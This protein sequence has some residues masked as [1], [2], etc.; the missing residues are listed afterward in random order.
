MNTLLYYKVGRKWVRKV[1]EETGDI[2]KGQIRRGTI[3]SLRR[4]TL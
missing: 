3:A 4:L 1:M 2:G